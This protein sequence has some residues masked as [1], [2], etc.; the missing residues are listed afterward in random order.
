MWGK[1]KEFK[2]KQW[3]DTREHGQERAGA[4]VCSSRCLGTYVRNKVMQTGRENRCGYDVAKTAV[5]SH[6]RQ[7]KKKD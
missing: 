2:L 5:Y 3:G 6:T 1:N 7:K 4:C